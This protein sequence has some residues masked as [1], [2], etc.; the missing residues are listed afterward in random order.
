VDARGSAL[1]RLIEQR[2]RFLSFLASRLE[3]RAIAEDVLQSAYVKAIEHGSEIR[4]HESTV[5]WFYRILRNAVVDHY[6]SKAVH[7]KAHEKF[8]TDAPT[9]YES[10][11]VKT[12]YA[13]I[14][15][16]VDDLKPE[17]RDAIEQV[18]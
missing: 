7:A 15:D 8:V 13:C 9:S 3:D 5:A 4:S 12:V 18:D 1:E 16:V 2:S 10:E 11:V 14:G 17:Y 6:R